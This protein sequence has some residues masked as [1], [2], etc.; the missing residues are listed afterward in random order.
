MFLLVEV[1]FKEKPFT[2]IVY[3]FI[4]SPSPPLLLLPC[5]H[6]FLAAPECLAI[7]CPSREFL[8]DQRWPRSERRS[9]LWAGFT[10]PLKIRI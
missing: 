4:A 5:T 9:I 10:S 6:P 2:F 8:I 7:V 1:L 3:K